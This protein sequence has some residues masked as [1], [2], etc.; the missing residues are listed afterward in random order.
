MNF[1]RLRFVAERAELGERREVLMCLRIPEKPGSYVAPLLDP[2]IANI[3][4]LSN[5]IPFLTAGP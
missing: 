2:Y 1:G 5:S 3:L 4:A